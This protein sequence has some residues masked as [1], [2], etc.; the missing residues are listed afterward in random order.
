MQTKLIQ[1]M[2]YFIHLLGYEVTTRS[3]LEHLK[4]KA[5]LPEPTFNCV[6]LAL[7]WYFESGYA[8]DAVFL[9][10]GAC[11]GRTGDPVYDFVCQGRM[12][13]YLLEPVP[14]TFESLQ[15]SYS[16]VRNVTCINCALGTES[17][18]TTMYTVKGSNDCQIAS[19]KREHVEKHLKGKDHR[20]IIEVRVETFEY[21]TLLDRFTIPT[22]DIVQID[23][24]GYDDEIV[25]MI[26][27]HPGELPKIINFEHLHLSDLQVISL[28]REFASRYYWIYDA[29]NTLLIR[30]DVMDSLTNPEVVIDRRKARYNDTVSPGASFY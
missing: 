12:R 19:F 8:H 9:Q 11:N 15:R 14:A 26:L 6:R 7:A 3:Y 10:V 5:R 21:S 29:W 20:K 17:K 2:R 4:Y 16:G 1:I 13:S 22:V 27:S 30:K 23:A 28:F 24:E 25:K 18:E